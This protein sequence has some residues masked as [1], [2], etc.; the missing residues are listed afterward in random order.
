MEHTSTHGK[1]K[2]L[3]P[4]KQQAF[5]LLVIVCL[6]ARLAP[7]LQMSWVAHRGK[8]MLAGFRRSILAVDADFNPYRYANPCTR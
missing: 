1:A 4:G 8:Q 2:S 3:R 5:V 6:N 7:S